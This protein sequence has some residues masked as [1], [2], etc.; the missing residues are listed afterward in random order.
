MAFILAI[1][2]TI[3][4]QGTYCKLWKGKTDILIQ[5]CGKDPLKADY[6]HAAWENYL[7]V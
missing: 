7:R 3:W 1:F 6:Y 4:T 5:K 2:N